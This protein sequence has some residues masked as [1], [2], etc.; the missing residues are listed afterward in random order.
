MKNTFVRKYKNISLIILVFIITFLLIFKVINKSIWF[1]INKPIDKLSYD[2]QL[3]Y[4]KMKIDFLN[5]KSRTTGTDLITDDVLVS[6][7]NGNDVSETDD[8]VRTFDYIKYML[9][10]GI[11]P[12][13]LASGVDNS[14]VFEGG[15]I[16]VRAVLPNQGDQ[17]IMRWETDAWMQNVSLSDDNRILYAEY[18]VPDG[19][20]VTNSNQNLSFTIKVDGY[21][22]IITDDMKPVFEVWMEGNKPDNDSSSALSVSVKDD[23]D[24]IIS[25][26]ESFDIVVT[27]G[28]YLNI[29]G[30][31]DINGVEVDGQY[32][33]YGVG[34]ALIQDNP[35]IRDNPARNDLKGIC[36]PS[37]DEFT[38]NLKMQYYYK[39]ISSNSWQ[40]IDSTTPDAIN[41]VN[42]TEII[43]SGVN[44]DTKPNYY[45]MNAN[46]TV[47]AYIKG[48]TGFPYGRAGNVL[49]SVQDSGEMF[50]TQDEENFSVTFKNYT[51]N[52]I[53]PDRSWGSSLKQEAYGK[54]GFFAT[55]NLEVFIPYYG[56]GLDVYD[57]QLAVQAESASTK[58]TNGEVIEI[59]KGTTTVADKLAT[60]NR[61]VVTVKKRVG[62]SLSG[63]SRAYNS[64]GNTILDSLYYYGNGALLPGSEF[65]MYNYY[66]L[67]D[68]PYDGGADA[69]LVWN[70]D[71]FAIKPWNNNVLV[72]IAGSSVNGIPCS[73]TENLKYYF[74]VYKANPEGG[75]GDNTTVNGAQH[76]DFDWYPTIDEASN[77]GKVCAL[78]VDDPDLEGFTMQRTLWSRFDTVNS[79]ENVGKVGIFRYKI[80]AYADE[81]RNTVYY[82]GGK[83]KYESNNGY[84]PASYNPD[85][86]MTYEASEAYGESILILGEKAGI[87]LSVSDTDDSGSL[88]SAY[89]VQDGKINFKVTPTITNDKTASDSDPYRNNVVIKTILPASL[90]YEQGSSN[91][92]PSSVVTNQDGSSILTWVYDNWQINHPAPEYSEI[93][94]SADIS[95][96][97][98]N[99]KHLEI[100]SS[101][102]SSGDIRDE[103][104]FRS[105]IYEVDISN[106][107]GS[108]T[109][110]E[111]DKSVVDHGES[112]NITSTLG[113][114]GKETLLNLKSLEILAKNGDE[115]GSSYSGTYTSKIVSG[116]VGQRFFYTT[117]S[118]DNIGITK[119]KYGKDTIKDVD[120]VNDSRWTQV[121][122]GDVIPNN[123]TAMAT[124]LPELV[125]NA[126]AKYVVQVN[127]IGNKALD[128]YVFSLTM[129]SD[130][131]HAAIKSNFIIAQC[132][133]RKISGIYFNDLNRNGIYDT[134][135]TLIENKKV[136]LYNSNGT[137]LTETMTDSNGRYL[138][139]KLDNGNY[140]VKFED[141][142]FNYEVIDKGIE[143]NSSKINGN[144]VSDVLD[145]TVDSSIVDYVIDNVNLGIRKKASKITTHHIYQDSN[146]E[147]KTEEQDKYFGDSYT[148]S[149]FDNLPTNYEF[150]S[151]TENFEGTVKDS[152]IDVVYLYDKKSSKI[153][154]DLDTTGT[155][156]ITKKNDE[157]SYKI[158]NTV[159]IDDYI[160]NGIV[161]VS[162]SLPYLIDESLS[163]LDEGVY[164]SSNKSITWVLN[165]SIDTY[166]NVNS[167]IGFEKNIKLVYR[168]I[169]SSIR[170]LNNPVSVNVL[171]D[172][173]NDTTSTVASTDVKIKGKIKV[174]FYKEDDGGIN[175]LLDT[176]EY[177]GLVGDE[178]SVDRTD[179]EGYE[180]S[181]N[182]STTPVFLDDDQDID[183]LYV[184]R[185]F[186]VKTRLINSYGDI[187]NGEQTIKYGSDSDTITIKSNSG[188]YIKNI[189]VNG[190]NVKL[191]KNT[192]T[193]DLVL[194]NIKEAKTI[195]VEFADI[196]SGP[197]TGDNIIKY[198]F[199]GLLSIILLGVIKT[200]K[201]VNFRNII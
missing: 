163:T 129:T 2:R 35:K 171:L 100:Y 1:S 20:N 92:E 190:E 201:K 96:T 48:A 39:L 19:T 189:V 14:S 38:I 23:R 42:G 177:E 6:D 200:V 157:V 8:Y 145:Q 193:Y 97:L 144:Y 26:H 152:V 85:G 36:Y 106:L 55:S 105:S 170:K 9:E 108:M 82:Y 127:P 98:D 113:N 7:D 176:E 10:V 131:L 122:V 148:T 165:K 192:T 30:K 17:T 199:I 62:G 181:D 194:E 149:V 167:S 142:G 52:G 195:E 135:D 91:K 11:T 183:L 120:L 118:V 191:N 154:F 93:T 22:K 169:D 86:T 161:T 138:F 57:Y 3:V 147:F 88:K 33:N 184:V 76:D 111:I 153:S 103:E 47:N 64:R 95:A 102:S 53:F 164:D 56:A 162:V 40:L 50:L 99:N 16:K 28:A 77:H 69:L 70:S 74:G 79:D 123:A 44:G 196:S 134:D 187:S 80:R 67:G 151:K 59:P 116:A 137:K 68:G 186:A 130:N 172:N 63:I 159:N 12:N 60:N 140:L 175:V 143:N 182:I 133:D 65:T 112:F 185:K 141:Y 107:V 31:R 178:L 156:E 73:S 160:G 121:F 41:L 45:P 46:G 51:L 119:D 37:T 125:A 27:T 81:E 61:S 197:I 66:R 174:H 179:L 188:Y 114:N 18:H 25:G 29:P 34:V 109:L 13:I 89:D 126:E 49:N 24:I 173:N 124:Y 139:E 54:Y 78:Y 72:N 71:F 128:K 150:I 198:L 155:N 94:F 87:D 5:I 4:D 84:V 180:L 21:K 43:E 115:D 166:N 110:K 75:I 158:T 136:E 90:T 83:A 32:A 117:N 104:M 146:T 15:V 58:K 101:I 132:I 168:N